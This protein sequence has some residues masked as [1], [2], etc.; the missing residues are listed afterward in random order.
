MKERV[1]QELSGR[2]DKDWL[3]NHGIMRTN[4]V[5]SPVNAAFHSTR[6]Q[7][8]FKIRQRSLSGKLSSRPSVDDLIGMH[9]LEPDEFDGNSSS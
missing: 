4:A 5:D 6:T 1:Q 8:E 3:I 7:L 9:I 2:H